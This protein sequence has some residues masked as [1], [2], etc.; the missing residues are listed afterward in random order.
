MFIY[1]NIFV[2]LL[3]IFYLWPAETQTVQ[4]LLLNL[5]RDQPNPLLKALFDESKRLICFLKKRKPV[6]YETLVCN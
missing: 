2:T 3:S 6:L 1:F 5:V 4:V